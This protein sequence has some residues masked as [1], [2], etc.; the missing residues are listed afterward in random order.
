MNLLLDDIPFSKARLVCPASVGFGVY[1]LQ[2][3]HTKK[4][5][6]LRTNSREW[7]YIDISQNGR[8]KQL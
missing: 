7:W 5:D 8:F 6:G 2:F 4:L 3:T 1:P